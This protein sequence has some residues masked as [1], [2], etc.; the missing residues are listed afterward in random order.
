MQDVIVYV[1]CRLVKM[2][3]TARIIPIRGQGLVTLDNEYKTLEMVNPDLVYNPKQCL[4]RSLFS[5]NYAEFYDT[6][7][8][9]GHTDKE[10]QGFFNKFL[11]FSQFKQLPDPPIQINFDEDMYFAN[12]KRMDEEFADM[13]SKM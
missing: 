10:T 13:L 1:P 4:P 12:E 2:G 11:L 6:C 8:S 3:A 9:L 7:M 5:K